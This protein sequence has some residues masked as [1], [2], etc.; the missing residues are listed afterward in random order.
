MAIYVVMEPENLPSDQ[1]QERAL[2]VRDGFHALAFILPILWLLLHRMW[3]AA[4]AAFVLTILAGALVAALGGH[5]VLATALPLLIGLYFGLEAP[6]LRIASLHQR[7]FRIWGTVEAANAREA[8]LRYA[9]EADH[10]VQAP[11]V[12]LPWAPLSQTMQRAYQPDTSVGLV[13]YPWSR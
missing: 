3:I 1:A 5:P 12:D 4:F 7:G 8:E 11:V 10:D 6:V 9:A 2:F 13:A